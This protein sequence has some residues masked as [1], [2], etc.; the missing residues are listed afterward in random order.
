LRKTNLAHLPD[1]K[2]PITI[3]NINHKKNKEYY[4]NNDYFINVGLYKNVNYKPRV[5]IFR[6]L[7]IWLLKKDKEKGAK[8]YV[9][10]GE[11]KKLNQVLVNGF[12][13]DGFTKVLKANFY[14]EPF[15]KYHLKIAIGD[16]GDAIFDSG[17]FLE[18]GS[19]NSI[20]DSTVEDFEDYIDISQTLDFDSIFGIKEA[21]IDSVVEEDF[22][23]TDVY[24]DYDKYAIPDT[25]KPSLDRLAAYL[26][27]NKNYRCELWGYTDNKGSKNYNQKLSEKRAIQ[28]MYYLIS[29][30]ISRRRMDYKGN[31]FSMPIAS[32]KTSS[33]RALNRRVEIILI[34]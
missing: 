17:V 30:G 32:N 11:K 18:E 25:T 26:N 33:G 3:N 14:V 10:E 15:Q 28:V 24:F 1:S 31:N 19:F 16:A 22:T 8:F 13:Y 29:K 7:W 23:I 6:K 5:S 4:I 27:E 12:Q 21:V 9:I 2:E 20:K 34:E